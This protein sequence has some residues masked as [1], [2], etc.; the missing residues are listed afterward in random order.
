MLQFATEPVGPNRCDP[1]LW[2]C[3]SSALPSYSQGKY[4]IVTNVAQLPVRDGGLAL[5]RD[6]FVDFESICTVPRFV[7]DIRVLTAAQVVAKA[8][9][10][11]SSMGY[12]LEHMANIEKIEDKTGEWVYDR[13]LSRDEAFDVSVRFIESCNDH[14]VLMFQQH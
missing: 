10:D 13:Q 4:I 12:S 5:R 7:A 6:L 3:A 14:A 2:R 8:A 1:A 11:L 9:Y